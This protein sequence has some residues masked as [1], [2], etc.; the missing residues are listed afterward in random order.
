MWFSLVGWNYVF[1]YRIDFIL[2]AAAEAF[3]F[4]FSSVYFISLGGSKSM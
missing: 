4:S 3:F 1:R 2:A